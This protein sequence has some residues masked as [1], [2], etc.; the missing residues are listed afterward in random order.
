M[1]K[2]IPLFIG[3]RYI[4]A[5]RRNQFISFIS[6]VSFLGMMLG[7]LALIVVLSVMNGFDR[8]LKG[9]I[10]SVVPHGYIYRVEQQN[11]GVEEDDSEQNSKGLSDW[12]ALAKQII[13]HPDV[14]AVAPYIKGNG[15]VSQFGVVRGIEITGV[16]PNTEAQV[17]QLAQDFIAGSFDSLQAGE[18]NIILGSLL[19]KHL[20]V[21]IGDKVTLVLPQVNI[22]PLG[23]FPRM[24]RFNVT[25]VF[26]AGAQLDGSATM[27][28]LDDAKK[29]FR[30]GENVEGLRVKV[31]DL[32]DAKRILQEVVQSLPA[33]FQAKDWSQTQGG[34][35]QAVKMEKT[36]I[37][38]LLMIVVAVAAFNIISILI[39]MVADKRSDIAVLRTLGASRGSI[40]GIFIIQGSSVGVIGT[41]VGA[42]LGVIL[43]LNIS[44]IAA[45][46]EHLLGLQLF[47]PDIYFISFLPSHLMWEDVLVVC[48]SALCLSFLA[49]LYPAYRA[50]QVQPAEALRYE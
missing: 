32:Y 20:G 24:K 45:F 15:M 22:T 34:L 10:L 16:L 42:V 1:L 7:I 17:S 8:E 33:G 31:A 35:F 9:R 21:A 41:V 50:A 44:T 6:A 28:H 14:V 23:I 3:L 38:L 30:Y 13:A 11:V 37:T 47:N 39:M 25:G 12:Q 19:A 27:I 2:Q 5:K 48:S 4:R 43:A 36:V 18:Y 40:M 46:I 29:L 49:T 26:Q